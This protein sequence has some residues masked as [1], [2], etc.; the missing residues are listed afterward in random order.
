MPR[1][2]VI[3]G[4][5]KGIG[6]QTARVFATAG[7]QVVIFDIDKEKGDEFSWEQKKAGK[8]VD[9]SALDITRPAD[10]Q[11]AVDSVV[12]QY[13]GI[14]VLVNC[15]GI[16]DLH[17]FADTTEDVWDLVMGINLKGAFLLTQA[18]LPYMTKA[19][20]G[21]IVNISSSAGRTG[22][23]KTG[24]S[25]SVS[26]AGVIGLTKTL[27]RM[28]APDKV[29]VNCIAPGTTNTEMARQFSS[30]ETEAI[31][32]QVP[33]KSLVDPEDIAQAVFFLA[34]DAAKMITG[35]CLDINGGIYMG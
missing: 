10:I 32:R 13:G 27:A 29:T 8:K 28:A 12:G 20:S 7:D 6:K 3:T 30:E 11:H 14:D 16:L 19:K 2:V 33:L 1:T 35:I 15:A 31:L 22:G 24:V 5:S 26:K 9:F 23:V 4:A 17:S 25:Y 21:R 34:S 18:V